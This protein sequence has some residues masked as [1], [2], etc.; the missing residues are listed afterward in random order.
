MASYEVN[1]KHRHDLLSWLLVAVCAAT[2]YMAGP[3][4]CG[5]WHDIEDVP[6]LPVVLAH[7]LPLAIFALALLSISTGRTKPVDWGIHIDR[8][9]RYD[10]AFCVILGLLTALAFEWSSSLSGLGDLFPLLLVMCAGL[11]V[12]AARWTSLIAPPLRKLLGITSSGK[13]LSEVIAF[14]VSFPVFFAA[15]LVCLPL[16]WRVVLYAAFFAG[17]FSSASRILLAMVTA[18]LWSQFTH[19]VSTA[20][21]VAGPALGLALFF[22]LAL[23][24]RSLERSHQDG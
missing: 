14:V 13:T 1:Q 2:L 5:H 23:A 3:V 11:M 12:L 20:V 6:I 16:G 17:I 15:L 4:F 8:S 9:L 7:V 22:A 21:R 18:I 10:V 24:A 19:E